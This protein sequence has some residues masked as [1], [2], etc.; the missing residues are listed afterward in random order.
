MIR[1]VLVRVQYY[2]HRGK[3]MQTKL[4]LSMFQNGKFLILAA[5]Q[6]QSQNGFV[7][8]NLKDT[9]INPDT[10]SRVWLGRCDKLSSHDYNDGD[11]TTPG[12]MYTDFNVWLGELSEQELIDWTS[13]Q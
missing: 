12:A 10:L 6:S 4:S 1:V 5:S 3:E 8:S 7:D 2:S 9:V 13:C 11:C